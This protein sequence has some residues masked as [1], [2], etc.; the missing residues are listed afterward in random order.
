MDIEEIIKRIIDNGNVEDMHTLS[1]I[2]EDT[3]EI[4]KKYNEESYKEYEMKL[5]RMAYGTTLSRQMA[6]E[7]VDK[8]QPYRTRWSYEDVRRIQEQ[9]R[10]EDVRTNDLFVVLNYAYNDYKDIFGE[11]V[12]TYIKFALDFINDED[13][14]D[15][16]VFLY[17]TTI[18]KD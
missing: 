6:E 5:Y 10:L 18:P 4:I 12:E 9:Y 14:K 7:I 15:G 2:L 11:D 13:A 16:K 17:F 8:M 1:D 3:M